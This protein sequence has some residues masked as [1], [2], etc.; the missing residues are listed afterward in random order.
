M[1]HFGSI[2]DSPLYRHKTGDCQI[3]GASQDAKG[4]VQKKQFNGRVSL[5]T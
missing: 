1:T 4:R 3:I 2:L 5:T